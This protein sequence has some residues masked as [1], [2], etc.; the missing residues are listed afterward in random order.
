M[1]HDGRFPPIR[2]GNSGTA[3]GIGW[4]KLVD[5]V[6]KVGHVEWDEHGKGNGDGKEHNVRLSV[7]A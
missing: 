5:G 3:I 1:A 2:C 4:V 6:G 7:I